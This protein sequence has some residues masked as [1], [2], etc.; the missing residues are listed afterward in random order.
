MPK[1]V[2]PILVFIGHFDSINTIF[3]VFSNVCSS[4]K[5]KN[6]RNK[7][8][9]EYNAYYFNYSILKTIVNECNSDE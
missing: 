4:E 6:S 8:N 1:I 2:I 9:A 5:Q 7:T 3:V